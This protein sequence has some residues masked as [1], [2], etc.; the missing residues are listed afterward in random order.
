MTGADGGVAFINL[1]MFLEA[2]ESDDSMGAAEG[3]AAIMDAFK[4]VSRVIDI[5]SEYDVS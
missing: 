1:R 4:L 2:L 3:K 5:S